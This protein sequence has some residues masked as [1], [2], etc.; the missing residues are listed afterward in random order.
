MYPEVYLMQIIREYRCL[1]LDR[2]KHNCKYD[3]N[4]H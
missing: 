4:T 1:S 3:D 2:S